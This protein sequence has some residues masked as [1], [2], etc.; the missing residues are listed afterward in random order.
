M[1]AKVAVLIVLLSAT[2]TVL[3][4]RAA[5]M[6]AVPKSQSLDTFPQ[7]IGT[8]NGHDQVIT[9]DV[10]NV[11]GDG[12]FLS[13]SYTDETPAGRA[14][15][16]L[17]IAYYPSQRSGQSIHSPQNCLPGAG[18]SFENHAVVTFSDAAQQPHNVAEYLIRNGSTQMEVLYWYRSRGQDIA[19]DYKAK[20]HLM[21][22]A[23]RD[24]RTDG[25]LIRVMT[26]IA[27][28]ETQQ[29]A[30]SRVIGFAQALDAKLNTFL[31]G[32]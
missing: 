10:R 12:Q 13:R 23:I 32:Q 9:Q 1:N 3:H 11:L 4:V 6:E 5:S 7:R 26:P 20:W 29:Q 27:D 18:W 2:A 22:Q 15:I 31:P 25:S 24:S 8:L 14:P 17:L 21:M 30:R 19:S 16:D 28:G